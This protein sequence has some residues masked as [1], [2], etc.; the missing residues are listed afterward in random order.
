MFSNGDG[1]MPVGSTQTIDW[2]ATTYLHYPRPN[3]NPWFHIGLWGDVHFVQPNGTLSVRSSNSPGHDAFYFA[4]VTNTRSADMGLFTGD[5]FTVIPLLAKCNEFLVF[6]TTYASSGTDSNGDQ[7]T[8]CSYITRSPLTLGATAGVFDLAGPSQR[9]L[10]ETQTAYGPV[11]FSASGP[12]QNNN[13]YLAVIGQ[14][15][16]ITGSPG[17]ASSTSGMFESKL[18]VYMITPT[19]VVTPIYNL[20]TST[21]GIAPAQ[22][23]GATPV[24]SRDGSRVAWVAS[25]TGGAADIVYIN[26]NQPAT[27]RVRFSTIY[28][29]NA[30]SVRGSSVI[31]NPL[32]NNQLIASGGDPNATTVG[33]NGITVLNY[34]AAYATTTAQPTVATLNTT[35]TMA[36]AKLVIGYNNVMYAHLRSGNVSTTLREVKPNTVGTYYL[37]NNSAFNYGFDLPRQIDGWNYNFLNT[38]SGPSIAPATATSPATVTFTGPGIRTVTGTPGQ[39]GISSWTV[40]SGNI[41]YPSVTTIGSV[42]S[43]SFDLAGSPYSIQLNTTLT[44]CGNVQTIGSASKTLTLYDPSGPPPPC[45]ARPGATSLTDVAQQEI[46]A[47]PNLTAETFTLVPKAAEGSQAALP[48]ENWT[49]RVVNAYG[50]QQ[51]TLA[52]YTAG[53]EISVR[54]WRQGLYQIQVT[55][56]GQKQ[57]SHTKVMVAQ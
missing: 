10:N 51:L 2:P 48:D 28:G 7:L 41:N 25:G 46:V 49:V 39:S 18:V 56:P 52:H 11:R 30:A 53:A 33:N 6:G 21:S 38:V 37:G 32:N 26:F 8:G 9:I 35:K 20:P 42:L 3:G 17:G 50:Q 27:N 36:R 40:T 34:T 12:D 24:V 4:D 23:V 16:G 22:F 29:S 13:F 45:C 5:N 44:T 15:T 1:S 55:R 57:P 43:R 19:G 47:L 54:D 14:F 31:F